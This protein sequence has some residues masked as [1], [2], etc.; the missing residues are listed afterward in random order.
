MGGHSWGTKESRCLHLRRHSNKSCR[1]RFP[2][3]INYARVFW[4]I[5]RIIAQR[6]PAAERKFK[7][8]I[9]QILVQRLQGG[10]SSTTSIERSLS[11]KASYVRA[12]LH[13]R[14]RERNLESLTCFVL[15]L[16]NAVLK[17]Y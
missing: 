12:T 8:E 1:G 14:G 7:D 17:D 11:R 15:R 3:S 16:C 10:E 9:S 13:H 4:Q 5:P 6:A 2:I